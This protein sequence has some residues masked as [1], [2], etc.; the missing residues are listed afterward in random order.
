VRNGISHNQVNSIYKDE[1]GFI[2]FGTMSG[3]NRYD[4]YNFK[5]FKNDPKDSTS[6]SDN[7]VERIL[8]LPGRKMLVLTRNNFNVYD[9]VT[10]KFTRGIGQYLRTLGLPES[11]L[12]DVKKDSNGNYWFLFSGAGLFCY[13]PKTKTSVS[14]TKYTGQGVVSFCLDGGNDLWL[15]KNS[16]VLEQYNGAKQLV[17]QSK[18]LQSLLAANNYRTD[19]IAD[20]DGDLWIRISNGTSGAHMFDKRNNT[21]LHYH[22]GGNKDFRISSNNVTGIIEG[23]NGVIW[24]S[25]DHGGVNVVDKK[26]KTI[27]NLKYDPYDNKSLT[28]NSVSTIF[29]DNSGVIW[30][31][32]FKRGVSVF[33]ESIIK[34]PLVEYKPSDSKGL[35]YGDV[36]RFIED[37]MGNLWIGTNGGGL[38]YY[39]RTKNTFTTY[40]HNPANRNSLSSDV[41][42]SLLIDRNKKLWIGTYFGGLDCFDGKSFKHYRHDP[43]DTNSIADDRIYELVQDSRGQLWI[44]TWNKG[45]DRFNPEKNTFDHFNNLFPSAQLSSPYITSL[46]EDSEQNLWIGTAYGL[47]KFDPKTKTN[48]IYK[49]NIHD[50]NTISKNNVSGILEDRRKLIWV[51]TRE[52]LNILDPIKNEVRRI[53]VSD[54]LPDNTVLD[55]VEVSESQLWVSTPNGLSKITVRGKGQL[56]NLSFL[57][58]NFNELNNLQDREFN[59]NAAGKLRT[60]E[61]VFGGPNGFNIFQ[62]HQITQNRQSAKVVITDMQVLNQSVKPGDKIDG[63]VISDIATTEAREIKLKYKENVFLLEFAALSY[64]QNEKEQYSYMLAG[65]D[66]NWTITDGKHRRA[67][68]TNLDPGTYYFKVRVAD[69]VGS[70]SD[71]TSLK[72]TIAPPFWRT[73]YA[74]AILILLIA[75]A[76]YL[77]R[78]LTLERARLRYSMEEQKREAQR[79]HELDMMKTKFFTNVSHEF[80]TPISLIMAPADKMLR[81]ANDESQKENLNLIRR[82][83]RRLLNMVNQLLDFRKLEEQELTLTLSRGDL[84]GF[85]KETSLSFLDIAENKQ[86]DFSVHSNLERFYT[87]FDHAKVERILF[88]LISNAFKFTPEYG[89]ISVNADI[90]SESNN[91]VLKLSVQDSGIGI[92]K[93][94]QEKIFEQ[95]FQNNTPGFISNY[96]SGIGLAIT[97]E[98]IQ[99]HSGTIEVQSE[100]N[101]GSTFIVTMPVEET[102]EDIPG[103]VSEPMPDIADPVEQTGIKNEPASGQKLKTVLLIEDNEDFRFYLKDNLK[104]YFTIIEAAN[105]KTGWQKALSGHPDLIVSDINMPEMNGID[106]CKKLKNDGRTSSIPVILLTALTGEEYHL[107]SLNTGADDYMAKP[108]NFEILLSRILNFL[109]RQE[110]LKKT[111]QRQVQVKAMEPLSVDQNEDDRFITSALELVERN[112]SNIDFSVEEMS[113]AL[114]LSRAGLYK[115]IFALTGKT[116][117]EFVREIRLQK[118]AKLLEN[119]NLTISE[120]AYEVGFSPKSF[121]KNFKSLYKM[122]PSE[123]QEI[124]KKKV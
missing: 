87:N 21:L 79:M 105:G 15:I 110:K 117:I 72:I 54:G 32:S 119:T 116:P 88:N 92:E 31:G 99:L 68:Y 50:T 19:I 42:V 69:A 13:Y 33:N 7:Y 75:A 43:S 36:N 11:L 24:I 123:Y 90:I 27:S 67:T 84:I 93:E 97:K 80:R 94:K 29:K 12:L 77:A 81:Q 63:R 39:D 49:N 51:G 35:S 108:F 89:Q 10:E 64:S 18:V 38:I 4:G 14:F 30:L 85:I 44:G 104:A 101:R 1:K 86:I 100:P 83:A 106:L 57:F 120:I 34:F 91:K 73:P 60:G 8:G 62:P 46:L 28:Q 71:A 47:N 118:A 17:Y 25:T 76:L 111:Y 66:K 102:A 107:Q 5:I 95:F 23:N 26:R 82:N 45:I 3:L 103:S 20:S 122:L 58:E 114:H 98:F 113:H 37:E 55:V 109:A 22:E 115:K 59:K 9:P 78:R 41:V 56:K 121:T 74:L 61:L 40:K 53:R 52:G 112:I 96:G 70:W 124:N 16:G 65:F 6:I 2:W 48:T